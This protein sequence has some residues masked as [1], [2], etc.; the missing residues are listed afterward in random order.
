MKR[1]HSTDDVVAAVGKL[2]RLVE[3]QTGLKWDQCKHS[4]D[5]LVADLREILENTP[6]MRQML[7]EAGIE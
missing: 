7:R 3:Y 5:S 1:T 2:V 4:E 6:D